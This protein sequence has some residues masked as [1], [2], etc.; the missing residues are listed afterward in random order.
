M[1]EAYAWPPSVSTNVV[2]VPVR[3]AAAAGAGPPRLAPLAGR[4][5]NRGLPSN[6]A[7]VSPLVSVPVATN[8]AAVILR[9]A[10][11]AVA[12]RFT[13]TASLA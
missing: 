8:E 7:D 13:T 2:A 5:S 1:I 12:G 9:P 11:V 3:S 4:S 10:A 6:R